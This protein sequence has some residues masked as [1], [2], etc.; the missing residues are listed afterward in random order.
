[1]AVAGVDL[2]VA[3][4]LLAQGEHQRCL[5][6]AHQA[7]IALENAGLYQERL[8]KQRIEEELTLARDIQMKLLPAP[9]R[10]IRLFCKRPG[11]SVYPLA[12]LGNGDSVHGNPTTRTLSWLSRDL[13]S[14]G[15]MT[16]LRRKRAWIY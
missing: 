1:M 4:V 10:R 7:A 8:E 14:W 12:D 2:Q 15:C 13:L 6:L 16:C 5:A 9:L 11:R 3:A